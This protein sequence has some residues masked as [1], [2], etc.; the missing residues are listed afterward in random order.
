MPWLVPAWPVCR[1]G[2]HRSTLSFL[3][4][5]FLL[6]C[7]RTICTHFLKY[8]YLYTMED[9]FMLNQFATDETLNSTLSRLRGK[10]AILAVKEGL[11]VSPDQE[12]IRGFRNRS[13]ELSKL[14]R[15]IFTKSQEEKEMAIKLYMKELNELPPINEPRKRPKK[16]QA[17]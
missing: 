9:H 13:L 3:Y 15:S 8:P 2:S 5:L 11:S 6:Y 1:L 12:K 17:S 16:I 4:F 10:L 7:G 14:V